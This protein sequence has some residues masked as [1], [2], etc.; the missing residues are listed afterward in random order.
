MSLF[1]CV[2]S[3]CFDCVRWTDEPIWGTITNASIEYVEHSLGTARQGRFVYL[4]I[5]A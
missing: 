4:A 1:L 3:V 2:F 5:I